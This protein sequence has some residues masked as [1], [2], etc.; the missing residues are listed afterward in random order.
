MMDVV[1]H[2]E[3]QLDGRDRA[4][5]G[6]RRRAQGATISGR[7]RSCRPGLG[8]QA[9]ACVDIRW[10]ALSRGHWQEPGGQ[11][12]AAPA[13]GRLRAHQDRSDSPR[14]QRPRERAGTRGA[15]RTAGPGAPRQRLQRPGVRSDGSPHPE[16]HGAGA[17][18][19]RRLPRAGRG[20]VYVPP[21][22]YATGTLVLKDNVTLWLEA[23]AVFYLSQDKA[24]FPSERAFVFADG[25]RNIAIRGRGGSTAR[26]AT[27][28]ALPRSRTRRSWRRSDWPRRRGSTCA[29]GSGAAFRP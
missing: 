7:R 8:R 15:R 10:S 6:R 18:R 3:W 29:G 1:R 25:A 23:G 17:A 20:T 22:E 26:P 2:A 14:P 16:R 4:L 24:D 13:L 11:G 12:T 5:H 9:D 28:G 27:S 21:G 19:H